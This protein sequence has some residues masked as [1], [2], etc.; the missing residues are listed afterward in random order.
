MIGGAGLGVLVLGIVLVLGL[1]SGRNAKLEAQNAPPAP[2]V[3]QP[4]PTPAP[5]ETAAVD[6]NVP[7]APAPEPRR[8]A[9][10]GEASK[11][12]E[13]NESADASPTPKAP[14][15]GSLREMI[16]KVDDGVVLITVYDQL[17][18]QAGLGSGFVVHASGRIATNFHVIDKAS[19]AVVKFRNGGEEEVTGYWIVDKKHDLA[20]LQLHNPPPD[21]EVL[22]LSSSREPQQGDEVVAIGH[23]KGFSFTVTNGIVSA[24]RMSDDLP[25]G[26]KQT[27]DAAEDSVWIQTTAAISGGNSGGPL[28][29]AAGEVIGVNTWI[30]Q[31]ENLAFAIDVRHLS[32]LLE[33]L[34]P[35]VKSLPVPG[36][37]A[38]L[39]PQVAAILGDFPQAYQK[40]ASTVRSAQNI[41]QRGAAMAA[42]PVPDYM[43]K[44]I[45]LADDHKKDRVAFEALSSACSL[46]LLDSGDKTGTALKKCTE[47]L[48]NDHFEEKQLSDIAL[49]SVKLPHEES[50]AFLTRLTKKSPHREVKGVATFALAA[51]LLRAAGPSNRSDANA[52]SLLKRACTEYGDVAIGPT[53]LSEIAGSQLF[54]LE[55]LSVGKKAV[56][57][58]GRDLDGEQFKLSD[59]AGKVVV[60]DFFA[61]WCPYCRKMY[62]QE[63]KM[64]EK[65]AQEPFALLGIN[66]DKA[67]KARLTVDLKRVTWRFW[68]DGPDGPITRQWNVSSFPTI[69]VLDH[70][71]T[72]RF[73]DVRGDDLDRAVEILLAEQKSDKN[74]VKPTFAKADATV[75]KAKPKV[76]GKGIGQSKKAKE[77]KA[78][79]DKNAKT[80]AKAGG[81][82]S[83]SV[84]AKPVDADP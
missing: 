29:N 77:A 20:V 51:A 21:L 14:G 13:A 15:K 26:V 58:E 10:D 72:I 60:L 38:S 52:I 31:G 57:I 9:T 18:R 12:P 23:P 41:D 7:A 48:L 47:R 83:T 80:D 35:A 8:A 78:K 71:G 17:G 34:P 28:L 43:N 56:D 16:D 69:Y 76:K 37:Q 68:W 54:A 61:D 1:R 11:P 33:R 6:A 50:R 67:E 45:K 53:K 30:A 81:K 19:R 55:H 75:E 4:T 40:Y 3:T 59:Y 63:Q 32:E 70:K 62:T 79:A 82:A 46:A 74:P 66:V 24:V 39:A 65:Y 49:L 36:G 42:N 22:K 5:V 44:L 84:K 64:V 27:L 25:E 73:R 2:I